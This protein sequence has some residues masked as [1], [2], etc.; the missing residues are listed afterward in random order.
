MRSVLTLVL[1]AGLACVANA[2]T[3]SDS[4]SDPD[5][6]IDVVVTTNILG[7]VVTNSLG[8]LVGDMVD[9]EV[10]MPLGADPHDFAPST[11]QAEAMTEA[12]VLV[13]N[14]AG[15]EAGMT[16]LIDSVDAPVLAAADV[17]EL[18]EDDGAIDPHLWT[19]PV[20][21]IQVV[22]AFAAEMGAAD[23]IDAGRLE[24]NAAAYVEELALLDQELETELSSIDDADRVLVT[25]HEVLGYFADRYD[26]EVLGAV[27][28]SLTTGAEASASQIEELAELIVER[29]VPA[30]FGETTQSTQLADAL[31]NEAGGDVVVVE[32]YSESLSEPD[33]EAGTYVEMMRTNVR[34][35]VEALSG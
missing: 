24:Q 6:R 21:M 16:N 18:L 32:L 34:L 2:C 14:G 13:V 20:R 28:P 29:D 9:V 7:D 3:G 8:D 1:I 12:D 15:F 17:V 5:D 10:I 19:D 33:G 11:R 25:N 4:A 30:V 27:I 31:S 22:E 23:G 35:I 26:F